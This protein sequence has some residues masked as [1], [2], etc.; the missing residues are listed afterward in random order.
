MRVLSYRVNSSRVPIYLGDSIS[1]L[2]SQLHSVHDPAVV[3]D[4]KVTDIYKDVMEEIGIRDVEAVYV[5]KASEENKNLGRVEEI[6]TYFLERKIRRDSVLF[7]IGGGITG[8]LAGFVASVFQRGISYVHV[9]TTLLAMVDSSIGGKV[10]V[11]HTLGK[12]MIGAFHHPASIIMHTSFLESLPKEELVCGLGEVAKYAVLRGEKFFEFLEKNYLRLLNK[13]EK[14]F[15]RIIRMSIET[16]KFFVERDAREAGVRSHLNL[17]HTVGHALEAATKYSTFKHGEAVLIGLVA[18]S[19][20][21]MHMKILRPAN[22]ERILKM[23]LQ[24]AR[25]SEDKVDLEYVL[26]R[27][28]FDKKMKA[29]RVRFILPTEMG[30]VIVRDDVPT[31]SIVDALRFVAADGLFA[32]T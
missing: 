3:I 14:I 16:K 2:G 21:A 8:D 30:K 19:H 32:L 13:D 4:S 1:R 11:N 28:A 26:G 17:G 22:F 12:N 29:G 20:I 27:L 6:V 24:I 18:E 25:R 31:K 10:G 7:A 9:P 23:V 15:E 5:F